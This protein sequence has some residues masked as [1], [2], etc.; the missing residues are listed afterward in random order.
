VRGAATGLPAT[1]EWRERMVT[2]CSER[3][4]PGACTVVVG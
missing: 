3:V 2:Q 1:R 4:R